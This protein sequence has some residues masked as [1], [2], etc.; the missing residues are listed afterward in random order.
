VYEEKQR[1]LDYDHYAEV[2]R[3]QHLIKDHSRAQ[4]KREM[5]RSFASFNY[6]A[7]QST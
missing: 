5:A 6:N 4:Q 7:A 3:V 1:A 2:V